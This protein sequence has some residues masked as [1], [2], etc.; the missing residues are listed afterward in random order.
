[1]PE[2]ESCC[3]YTALPSP[4]PHISAQKMEIA[5]CLPTLLLLPALP[6]PLCP[7]QVS[8]VY[9][10]IC[11]CCFSSPE[12]RMLRSGFRSP[13]CWELQ[14]AAEDFRWEV[15]SRERGIEICSHLKSPQNNLKKKKKEP[16]ERGNSKCFQQHSH[17][18]ESLSHIFVRI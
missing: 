2:W 16:D 17:S 11:C 7:S 15:S 18:K 6:G 4:G 9:K 3:S 13:L 1:M 12:V 8:A 10:P 5:P 14:R